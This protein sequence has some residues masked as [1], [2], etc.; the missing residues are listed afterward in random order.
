MRVVALLAGMLSLP[1]TRPTTPP[2]ASPLLREPPLR[3]MML[4]FTAGLPPPKSQ[5]TG[6]RRQSRNLTPI[7][8]GP[9]STSPHSV[10]ASVSSSVKTSVRRTCRSGSR[11]KISRRSSASPRVRW[12]PVHPVAIPKPLGRRQWNVTTNP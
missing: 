6:R 8:Y 3:A 4:G 11:S 9:S 5:R 7:D 2:P 10:L 1:R 12:P